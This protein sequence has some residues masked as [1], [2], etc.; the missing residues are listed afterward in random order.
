MLF[1]A[2]N[3]RKN[4]VLWYNYKIKIKN[5]ETKKL[6]IWTW[7]IVG[8]LIVFMLWFIVIWNEFSANLSAD[9]T[10]SD[11]NVRLSWA[12]F[13]T[14][15]DWSIVNENVRYQTKY[16]VYLDGWPP[17]NAPSK[18]AWLP[19]WEY[20]FQITDPSWKYLLGYS[21]SSS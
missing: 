3:K 10:W 11:W 8:A 20:V 9:L 15:P 7:S 5:M 17:I 16:H 12:I 6:L 4:M 13:T 14:T 21:V 19:A 2:C 18:A 1:K